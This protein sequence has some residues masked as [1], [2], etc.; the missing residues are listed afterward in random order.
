MR[1]FFCAYHSLLKD[2]EELTDEEAGALF[3]ACLSYSAT[4]EEPDI[5][6]RT[7]RALFS[8]QKRLIDE[9]EAAYAEKSEKARASVSA[10]YERIRTY[11]NEDKKKMKKKM[12]MNTP[13]TG[14]V[15]GQY[16]NASLEKLEVKL[17]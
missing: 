2:W 6:D 3:R 10:R 9:A 14:G 4:G 15:G 1:S 5:K 13:L 7:L 16:S 11:T 12:N 8:T 17:I